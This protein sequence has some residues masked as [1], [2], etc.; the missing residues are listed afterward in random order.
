[1]QAQDATTVY[2]LKLWPR[3]EANRNRIIAGAVIA[4]LMLASLWVFATQQAQKEGNAGEAFTRLIIGQTAQP[5]PYLKLAADYA[6]TAAGQRAQLEGASLLFSAGKYADAQAQFQKFIDEHPDSEF[7]SQA[8]LGV[9]VSLDA[10]GKTDEAMGRYQSMMNG[11]TDQIA[12]GMAKLALARIDEQ[13]GKY[14][15]AQTYYQ[16][17]ARANPNSSLANDAMW[18]LMELRNKVPAVAPAPAPAPSAPFKL[19]K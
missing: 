12:A 3:I 7:S 1:M 19:T 10:Q 17:V 6:G 13:K 16:E 2:L 11:A 5:E 14:T 15:E 8:A 4:V 18:H 9:A